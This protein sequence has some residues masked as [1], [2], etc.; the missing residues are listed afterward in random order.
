MS[1]LL[2]L[3]FAAILVGMAVRHLEDGLWGGAIRLVNFVTAAVVATNF[4][5][6][7][8]EAMQ[9]TLP[10]AHYVWDI[11]AL[12][13]P[14]G[15]TLLLLTVVTNVVSRVKVTFPKLVDQI[16]GALLNLWAGWVLVCFM[17]MTLHTAPIGRDGFYGAL[18]AEQ[19]MFF[20]SHP[21]RL[22]LSFAQQLSLGPFARGDEHTFDPKAEFLIRYTARRARFET[23]KAMFVRP[24]PDRG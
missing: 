5:E 11:I 2:P 17:A 13:V 16:G 1:M 19:P 6:P 15:L 23:E 21:D 22:W 20:G 3:L 9:N 18:S 10:E 7:I 24:R 12:W 14:F 8:A 4:F